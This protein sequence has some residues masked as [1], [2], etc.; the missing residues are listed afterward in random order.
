MDGVRLMQWCLFLAVLPQGK[1]YKNKGGYASTTLL[2]R[3]TV[4]QTFNKE[5]LHC[6]IQGSAQGGSVI[7]IFFTAVLNLSLNSNLTLL[8]KIKKWLVPFKNLHS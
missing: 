5:V 7:C 4:H 3:V 8:G 6:V 2:C 1:G